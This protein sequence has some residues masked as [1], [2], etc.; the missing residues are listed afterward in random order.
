MTLHDKLMLILLAEYAILACV[1][2]YCHQYG[3][4]VYWVGAIVLSLGVLMQR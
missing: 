4:A 2:W 1:A 3:K